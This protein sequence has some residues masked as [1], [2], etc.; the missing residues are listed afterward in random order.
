MGCDQYH[1][2][3]DQNSSPVQKPN[4]HLLRF[5]Q[6]RLPCNIVTF[7]LSRCEIEINESDYHQP[8]QNC[9]KET[10]KLTSSRCN[11]RNRVRGCLDN[12]NC[13]WSICYW[14][15]YLVGLPK[16][17]IRNDVPYDKLLPDA[18]ELFL[19]GCADASKCNHGYAP[20]QYYSFIWLLAYWHPLWIP[21]RFFSDRGAICHLPS[22]GRWQSEIIP[23]FGKHFFRFRPTFC[24]ERFLP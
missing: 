22:N 5:Q 20:H 21:V 2:E 3:R 15:F 8:T 24:I 11:Y 9:E 17:R 4:V 18:D 1:W 14:Q 19:L 12:Q 10:T 13:K 7:W 16:W 23:V 6:S